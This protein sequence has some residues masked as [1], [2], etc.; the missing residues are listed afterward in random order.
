MASNYYYFIASLPHVNY[1]DKPPFASAEFTE[2]CVNYLSSRDVNLIHY[3]SYDP[4]LSLETVASTGSSFIDFILLRER[5]MNM[6]LASLRGA[7][8]NRP[9][10]GEVSH[11]LPRAEA[12]AKT[13]FEMDD[14]LDAAL[15]IDRGRWGVLDEMV[16]VNF[17]SANNVFAYFFKLQLLERK[18]RFDIQK[19][20][21]V[22]RDL[23][24]SILTKF[25]SK[26]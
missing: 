23:Y 22:Y 8:L 12:V 4:K 13:A 21:A 18:Q 19:G 7:K 2:R 24:D 20:A 9:F 5:V 3:C 10:N 25:N 16:G 1:G 6:T 11:D 26:V 14:P 15:F 17:F